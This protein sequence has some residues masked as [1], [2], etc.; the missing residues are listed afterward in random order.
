MSICVSI[1]EKTFYVD[2]C[3]Y[4]SLQ[5]FNSETLNGEFSKEIT[6]LKNT[7]I[8]LKGELQFYI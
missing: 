8:I 7:V 3:H 2:Q 4:G 6:M 5:K 1:L